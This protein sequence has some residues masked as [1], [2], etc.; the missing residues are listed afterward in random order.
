[1][2]ELVKASEYNKATIYKI[3]TLDG[4]VYVG[5]TT[6]FNARMSKHKE[7]SLKNKQPVSLAIGKCGFNN[8]IIEILEVVNIDKKLEREMYWIS[9]FK[10]NF[11]RYPNNKGLNSTDVG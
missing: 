1:M 6:K 11:N 7:C 3:T 2:R 5:Q 8:C 4:E 9:Y 10:S